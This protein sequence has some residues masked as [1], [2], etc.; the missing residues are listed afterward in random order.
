[1]AMCLTLAV[2]VGVLPQTGMPKAI[3]AETTGTTGT[4]E[5]TEA[6]GD[7][8]VVSGG[9]ITVTATPIPAE[10]LEQYKPAVPTVGLR[11]GSKRVRVTWNK[12]DGADGYCIYSRPSTDSAYTKTDTIS[13]GTVTTYDKKSLLQNYNLLFPYDSI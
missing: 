8:Q 13:D 10:D 1:M 2:A 6:E 7:S 9:S 5:T 11:G 12:I 3:A 4:T